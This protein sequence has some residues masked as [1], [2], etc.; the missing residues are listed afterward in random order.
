VEASP[1]AVETTGGDLTG[2]I[3]GSQVSELP[4]N[5][6]NFMQ[7]VTLMPVFPRAK[8]TASPI[9]ASRVLES[10]RQWSASNGN[11]W[12]V[13]GANNN[14]RVRSAPFLSIFNGSI[15]SSKIERKRLQ[16]GVWFHGWRDCQ[17][18]NQKREESVP[19]EVYYLGRNDKLNAYDTISKLVAPPV[20]R[21]SSAGR[22]RL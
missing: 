5:G 15:E 7:L 18:R 6:R 17:P 9:R 10:L 12:L 22:I 13:D 3:E 14:D 8:V 4:L 20:Q 16:R 1:V 21:V 11:Q 2:L 19:R